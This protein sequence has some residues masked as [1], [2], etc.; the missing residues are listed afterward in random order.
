MSAKDELEGLEIV[1]RFERYIPSQ[2]LEY[3]TPESPHISCNATD[4][5]LEHLW[6]HIE[7]SPYK[8]RFSLLNHFLFKG[9]E[10]FLIFYFARIAKIYLNSVTILG[11][12]LS[13]SGSLLLAICSLVL[14]PYV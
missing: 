3:D 2:H 8:G 4:V 6:T 13:L 12:L 1:L 10:V 7:R 5:V 9:N 14:D 11:A